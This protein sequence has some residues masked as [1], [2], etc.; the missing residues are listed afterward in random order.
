[1]GNH[2]IGRAYV[3]AVSMAYKRRRPD[4]SAL[5]ILDEAAEFTDIRGMDAEFDDEPYVDGPFRSLLLEAFGEGYD[6]ET[7]VDGEGFYE[8]VERAFSERYE[9]C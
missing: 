3:A 2:S 1:M 4:E 5:S 6:P 8:T 9:L 7:D